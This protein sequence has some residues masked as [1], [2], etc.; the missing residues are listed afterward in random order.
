MERKTKHTFGDAVSVY[1][2]RLLL[3]KKLSR[4]HDQAIERLLDRFEH[5]LLEEI[6]PDIW[7]KYM[8]TKYAG[9]S[10]ATMH[11]NLKVMNAIMKEAEF[12]GWHVARPLV[13]R[14]RNVDKARNQML[15]PEEIAPFIEY[16]EKRHGA[17][18]AFTVLLLI[19]T[20]M[21]YGE[22]LFLRWCDIGTEWIMV[23]K[24]EY[25]HTKTIE[26]RV[27]T[28][29]RLINFMEK[30]NIV[31]TGLLTDSV[32]YSRW[33]R[34]KSAISTKLNLAIKDSAIA[35]GC[36]C[37]TD[38]RI[39]DLRHTFANLCA[40]AGADLGDLKEMMGHTNI[41]VTMRYRGLVRKKAKQ[42]IKDAMT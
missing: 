39:H 29:P 19:D 18:T 17:L 5:E 42:I 14:M 35:T 1:R 24:G 20:G 13:K 41:N 23:R 34:G 8:S 32:I 38:L 3:E 33:T 26:R 7:Y 6:T 36:E 22:A 12:H 10:A 4:A 21:R 15:Q 37:G 40:S 16:M 27:P 9:L 31:P 11:R 2:R 28:S 30:H 25:G